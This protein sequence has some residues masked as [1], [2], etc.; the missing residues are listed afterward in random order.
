MAS[1]SMLPEPVKN[2]AMLFAIAPLAT[3]A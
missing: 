1:A 3:S 2:A